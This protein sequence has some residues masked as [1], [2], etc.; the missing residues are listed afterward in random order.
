MDRDDEIGVGFWVFITLVISGIIASSYKQ[1]IIYAIVYSF[2]V[3]LFSVLFILG[4]IKW[5][6]VVGCILLFILGCIPLVF[7][8][9]HLVFLITGVPILFSIFA[10]YPVRKLEERIEQEERER[11]A[12]FEAE[13][14]AKGL[15][16][17]VD[18]HCKVVWGTPKQVEEWKK[19]DM[20]LQN[21]FESL[22]PREFEEFIAKLFRA[23][24]YQVKLT[25]YVKDM[26]ADI[27]AKNEKDT[28]LIQ[29]KKYS[30]GHNVSNK[31]VQQT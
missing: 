7:W 20:L 23:M 31:E 8:N 19:I 9:L 25:P 11:R 15:V 28:I 17:F 1:P 14:K 10:R 6:S 22:S 12:R 27:L 4:G 18:R 26:G 3:V 30:V 2:W 5:V 29:V 21:N 16:K 13:Q 24:G